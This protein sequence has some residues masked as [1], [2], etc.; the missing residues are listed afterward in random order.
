MGA[1]LDGL[2]FLVDIVSAAFLKRTSA[3]PTGVSIVLQVMQTVEA[4]FVSF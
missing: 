4:V 3:Q 1:I 2:S